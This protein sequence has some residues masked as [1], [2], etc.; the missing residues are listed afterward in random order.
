MHVLRSPDEAALRI[1]QT[2]DRLVDVLPPIA[3]VL[4]A[5]K[6]VLAESARIKAEISFDGGFAPPAPDPLRF[7]QGIPAG[8]GEEGVARVSSRLNDTAQRMISILRQSFPLLSA[9]LD[10]LSAGLD[11]EGW[12][13]DVFLR[14]FLADRNLAAAALAAE[15]QVDEKS[16]LFAMT[17]ALKPI[18][19]KAAELIEPSIRELTWLKGCCPICGSLPE[20]SFIKPDSSRR[21]L[22]CSLCAHTWC[23]QRMEC[24]CCESGASG[25]IEY[26]YVD[27]KEFERVEVCN[28]CMKYVVALDLRKCSD[29]PMLELA[30]PALLHLDA[31]ARLRG[32]HPMATTTWNGLD[33]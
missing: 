7:E 10:R 24:P 31:I 1:E 6:K 22:R 2:I 5:F 8:L 21:F 11:R 33:L 19:E 12:N 20:L 30:A 15:V 29:P 13:A 3:N 23:F 28:K 26:L 17:A 18:L 27:E 14:S 9:N 16:V 4:S 25:S 32:Y